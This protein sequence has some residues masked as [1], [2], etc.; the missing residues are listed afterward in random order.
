MNFTAIWNIHKADLSSFI[1]DRVASSEIAED[2]L[3]E[4]A[5]KF[6]SALNDQRV[7]KHKSWLFQVT[8]NTIADFYRKEYAKQQSVQLELP[9]QIAHQTYNTC[10]CDLTGF[11]I[12]NYLPEKYGQA[13]F[14]SDIENIPHKKIADTLGI[15]LTATKSRIQRARKMLKTQVEDCVD[16]S[17]DQNGAVSDYQLKNDC[18]LPPE[19][20]REIERLNLSV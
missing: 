18:N 16:L 13:L 8:R 9:E 17:F 12:T 10:V 14:M 11:V 5:V 3:Q 20:L 7:T 15:S 2:I 19:L 1:R 6:Y 4:V